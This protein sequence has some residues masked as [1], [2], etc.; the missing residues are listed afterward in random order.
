MTKTVQQDRADTTPTTE[1]E[2]AD[3]VCPFC[4]ET[5]FDL[6]GLKLHLTRGH[7]DTFEVIDTKGVPN[8]F[9]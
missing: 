8:V 7:C 9:A 4:D 6:L 2:V 3:I 5:D 1:L